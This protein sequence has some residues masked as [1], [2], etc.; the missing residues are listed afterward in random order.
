MNYESETVTLSSLDFTLNCGIWCVYKQG[1]A[2]FN[3]ELTRAIHT[4]SCLFFDEKLSYTNVLHTCQLF[5]FYREYTAKTP[6]IPAKSMKFL[7]FQTVDVHCPVLQFALL[8]AITFTLL[9]S[10]VLL[11]KH[12]KLWCTEY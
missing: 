6:F 9:T 3:I 7:V 12:C 11:T 4:I 10:L 5:R 1:T 8:N 2:F